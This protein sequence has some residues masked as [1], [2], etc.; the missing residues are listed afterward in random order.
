M[1]ILSGL[2][3]VSFAPV[4]GSFRFD[5]KRISL[6]RGVRVILGSENVDTGH[7]ASPQN[8]W[9]AARPTADDSIG[10]VSPLPLSSSHVE[11]RVNNGQVVIRDLDSP[12]GTFVNNVKI[13][14]E[15]TLNDGDI[16]RLGSPIPRNSRTPAYI[17]DD[18]LKPI[19]AK[20]TILGS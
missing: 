11:L 18:H 8:G 20:I 1:N 7:V 9:F 17:T 16:V 13:T 10:N 14:A 2:P 15:T 3:I 19:I 12:F 4:T 5:T 6:A